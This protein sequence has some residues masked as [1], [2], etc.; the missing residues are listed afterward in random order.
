[1]EL[2]RER[3]RDLFMGA[4]LATGALKIL[5]TNVVGTG[6]RPKTKL[7]STFLGISQEEAEL[8]NCYEEFITEAVARGRLQ[9]PGFFL[10]PA[11]RA[12]WC[13]TEWYGTAQGQID[14][15]KEA[16]AAA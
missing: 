16:K 9:A 15:L 14:P 3:C 8:M 6:I 2:M 11:I 10:D 5:R 13:G 12:A 1:M 4:P 7:D